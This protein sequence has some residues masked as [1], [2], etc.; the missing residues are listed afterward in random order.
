MSQDNNEKSSITKT[1]KDTNNDN[2]NDDDGH[3]NNHHDEKS[4][5]NNKDLF[6]VM[7]KINPAS[8]ENYIVS[9]H[10]QCKVVDS[11]Q[12]LTKMRITNELGIYGVLVR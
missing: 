9:A 2:N 3:H 12:K 6:I 10:S 5:S 1:D 4:S 11:Q 7:N 8:S